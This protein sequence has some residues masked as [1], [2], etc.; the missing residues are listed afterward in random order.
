MA[1]QS[2]PFIRP[3][4]PDF[5]DVYLQIGWDGIED[6][7]RAHKHTIKRWV[8]ECGGD[9]LKAR[10]RDAVRASRLSRSFIRGTVPEPVSDGIAVAEEIVAAAAQHLRR[11]SGGGWV[12]SPT[13]K[14][15]WRI[16]TMRKTPA[17]VVEMAI[18]KGFDPDAVIVT[19]ARG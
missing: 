18:R 19:G 14:G 8:Q 5:V 3:C 7:F 10:R 15:D 13:G 4:P 11:P 16:G 1:Q 12:V 2:R 9:E 6:H 17:E